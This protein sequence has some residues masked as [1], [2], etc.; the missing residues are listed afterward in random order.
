M[1]EPEDA[2]NHGGPEDQT[3]T[4]MVLDNEAPVE[5]IQ[6]VVGR[7]R[8]ASRLSD[9]E[10]QAVPVE[11]LKDGSQAGADYVAER[12]SRPSSDLEMSELDHRNGMAGEML[13]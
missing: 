6:Q 8:E 12:Q 2:D 11:E 1:Q 5:P 9:E 3:S 7:R 4:A 10:P 13:R